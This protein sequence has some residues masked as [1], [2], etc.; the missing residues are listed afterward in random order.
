MKSSRYDACTWRRHAIFVALNFV[1]ACCGF[2][3]AVDGDS[4]EQFR[5]RF[6]IDGDDARLILPDG[7][8][9]YYRIFV[10]RDLK[11]GTFVLTN[12]VLGQRAG[13][14][15]IERGALSGSGKRYYRASRIS[16]RSPYD[17]DADGMDDV[18]ELAHCAVLNALD[19]SDANGDPDL[20]GLANIDEYDYRSDPEVADT[21][22]DGVGD[23]REVARSTDPT[24]AQSCNVTLYV[25]AA[26][27]D[28]TFD[29]LT[30]SVCGN[31]GPK[32]NIWAALEEAVDGDS[33][34]ISP[35]VY[36]EMLLSPCERCRIVL[37]PKGDVRLR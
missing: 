3:I 17:S 7:T 29:G 8:G 23:G 19:C 26:T 31:R 36:D 35:G 9:V 18:F 33:V 13:T 14:V 20:D 6:A 27:G 34:V 16:K 11:S 12:L 1:V 24:D 32:A 37:V 10:S 5:V 25:D 15:L 4:G 22:G 30:N 21:D 2:S 28:N